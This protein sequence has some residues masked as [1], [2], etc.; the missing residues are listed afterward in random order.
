MA[1][2]IRRNQERLKEGEARGLP[3][4]GWQLASRGQRRLAA[5]AA[6]TGRRGQGQNV[7]SASTGR[8]PSAGRA[9]QQAAAPVRC[10]LCHVS[11]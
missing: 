4:P 3:H 2:V 10:L 8:R 5:A 6:G 11:S 9:A 1:E 7:R